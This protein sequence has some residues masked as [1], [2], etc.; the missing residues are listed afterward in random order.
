MENCLEQSQKCR[1]WLWVSAVCC[2]CHQ[3]GINQ[4]TEK[5]TPDSP[6]WG[7]S[8]VLLKITITFILLWM[9]KISPFS[10]PMIERILLQLNFPFWKRRQF[11]KGFV[12][13]A[14]QSQGSFYAP[15][16]WYVLLESIARFSIL[17]AWKTEQKWM[18]SPF[19]MTNETVPQQSTLRFP[20]MDE[21]SSSLA[22]DGEKNLQC[23][24]PR[25]LSSRSSWPGKNN[26]IQI[27]CQF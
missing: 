3:Y 26:G 13:S 7:S 18:P 4:L 12:S 5:H 25:M 11:S 1:G 10:D 19:V 16:A 24:K 27:R 9:G 17:H 2:I 14:S 21:E 6:V 8:A 23:Q 15:E 20:S 22:Q